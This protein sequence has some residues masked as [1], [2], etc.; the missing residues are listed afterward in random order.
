MHQLTL[1]DTQ[2]GVLLKEQGTGEKQNALSIVSPFLTPVLVNGRIISADAAQTQHAFCFSLTRWDGDV[3]LIAKHKQATLA[4]DWRL[5]CSEPPRD[6]RDWRTAR[7][8]NKGHARLAIRLP[9]GQSRT[10]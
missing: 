4:D 9:A 3:V 5:F 7:T 8:V 1:D 6:C 2:T 10:E